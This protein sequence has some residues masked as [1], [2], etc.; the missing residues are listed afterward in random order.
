MAEPE[1]NKPPKQICSMR[2]VFPVDTDEQA[3]TYKKKISYV[4]SEIAHARIEFTLSTMPS[5]GDMY[6]GRT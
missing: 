3:I 1:Q 2:I 6:A 5:R 4:L